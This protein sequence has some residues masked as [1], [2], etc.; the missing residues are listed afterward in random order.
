MWNSLDRHIRNDESRK[1]DQQ[2]RM[3]ASAGI[4]SSP[5][6]D[7]VEIIRSYTQGGTPVDLKM[8]TPTVIGASEAPA[9]WVCLQCGYRF[10]KHF[11]MADCIECF[12]CG[13]EAA[14]PEADADVERMAR[15]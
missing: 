6:F 7:Q 14:V 9:R 2:R 15:S 5:M 1:V 10:F 11:K 4:Q 13:V 8:D 12:E 3:Q